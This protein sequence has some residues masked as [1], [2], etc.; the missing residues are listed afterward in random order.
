MAVASNSVLVSG[1]ACYSALGYLVP[2]HSVCVLGHEPV[3]SAPNY[4]IIARLDV[5]TSTKLV[6]NFLP[7]NRA[8]YGVRCRGELCQVFVHDGRAFDRKYY[9]MN[10]DSAFLFEH[11]FNEHEQYHTRGG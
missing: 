1:E 6:Y 9:L 3:Y 4:T 11:V 10:H 2:R 7:Q 8:F 5:G